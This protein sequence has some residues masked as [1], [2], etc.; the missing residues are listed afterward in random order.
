MMAMEISGHEE[1]KKR[2]LSQFLFD[3]GLI[4]NDSYIGLNIAAISHGVH[5]S[6]SWP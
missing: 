1:K 3:L 2:P 6:Y 4:F 5:C